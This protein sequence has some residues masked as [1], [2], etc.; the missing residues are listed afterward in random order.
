MDNTMV[1]FEFPGTTTGQYDAVIKDLQNVN[2][3]QMG[4]MLYHAAGYQNNTL[5]VVDIW[6]SEDYM[7][8]FEKILMPIIEKHKVTPAK[9]KIIPIHNII[10]FGKY[11]MSKEFSFYRFK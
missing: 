1:L 3:F 8:E 10:L 7:K 6:E 2:A 4:G 11:F 5:T 9:P